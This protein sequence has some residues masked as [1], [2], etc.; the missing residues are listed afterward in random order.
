MCVAAPAIVGAV[1]MPHAPI[2]VP[3]VGRHGGRAAAA[4]WQAM[5][6]A[7]AA[8]MKLAPETVIVIS[9]HSPRRPGAFGL[10]AGD[11]LGDSFAQFNAPHTQ[12]DL[13]NDQRLIKAIVA[14]APSVGVD[15][16]LIQDP[17]LDHGALVPLWFLAQAG[18]AGPTVV[19][20]LNYPDEGGLTNMGQAIRSA[21]NTLH[22]RVAIV[23]SGDMSHCLAPDA[24][25]G[26]HPDAHL[27]DQTFIRLIRSGAYQDLG[28][29]NAELWEHAAEDAVDSTVVATAAA[30]GNANGH[31]VLSYEAPF[32]VGYGVAILF[33]R[34]AVA[35]SPDAAAQMLDSR[36]GHRL[37][38]LAR[39]AA[40]TALDGSFEFPPAASGEYLNLQRGVFVTVHQ[41]NGE[42]RGCVGTIVPACSNLVTETWRNARLAALHD[43]RFA[44]VSSEEMGGLCFEVSVLHPP[45]KVATA[46]ELDPHRYGVIVSTDDGRRGLLLP[47]IKQIKT[48][49]QQLRSARAKASICP[50]EPVAI[51][52]FEVDH[53]KESNESKTVH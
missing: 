46:A 47:G 50:H 30:D 39:R 8:V 40:A 32:G 33:A 6:A 15:T 43:D 52:R 1:L 26:F 34:P 35:E 48:P 24:P 14:A 41:A 42:L 51:Q 38:G 16:W 7:A 4:S 36:D 21:A 19:V 28:N 45:E 2:L 37:P 53:F 29:I 49:E 18:W 3:N 9:P 12:V 17:R 44:P 22:R 5:C 11:R 20:S 25:G 27:F 23:A 10:W 13:P 31:N